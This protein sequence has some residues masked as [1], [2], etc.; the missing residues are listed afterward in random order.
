MA[1]KSLNAVVDPI[2][3]ASQPDGASHTNQEQHASENAQDT[4]HA[5]CKS[6]LKQGTVRMNFSEITA[7]VC[8]RVPQP[9]PSRGSSETVTALQGIEQPK[10]PLSALSTV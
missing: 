4:H 8:D 1:I 6:P 9:G 2:V 7:T 10:W 5:H 3:L